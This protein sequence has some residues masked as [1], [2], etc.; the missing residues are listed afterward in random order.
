MSF[1]S[2]T[3]DKI[4]VMQAYI[5]G[6]PIEY[7][8]KSTDSW[9]SAPKIPSWNWYEYDYRI[10]LIPYSINWEHVGPE[11]KYL[12]ADKNGDVYLYTSEPSITAYDTYWS[13]GGAQAHATAFVSLVIGN[14]DWTKSLI[15]RP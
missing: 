6:R 8:N 2:E 7:R 10:I 4:K 15:E 12:A 1:V 9:W 13:D 11:F 3:E 5:D 14:V